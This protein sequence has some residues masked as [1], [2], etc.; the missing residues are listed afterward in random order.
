MTDQSASNATMISGV[1]LTNVQ[2]DFSIF[3]YPRSG[4]T[5]AT[6]Y[7]THCAKSLSTFVGKMPLI[8]AA[9][10]AVVPSH[11]SQ[12]TATNPQCIILPYSY[13]EIELQKL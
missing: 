12:E 13:E 9:F 8:I 5:V 11:E 1:L 7:G 2:S 4:K 10:G 3:A 6:K